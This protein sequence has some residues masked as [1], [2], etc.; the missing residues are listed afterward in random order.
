MCAVR[1]GSSAAFSAARPPLPMSRVVDRSWECGFGFG[2]V[3][4]KRTDLV[5][6]WEDSVFSFVAQETSFLDNLQEALLEQ[7]EP[8][9]LPVPADTKASSKLSQTFSLP[10]PKL[11]SLSQWKPQDSQAERQA[12]LSKWSQ[13]FRTVPHFFLEET[14]LEVVHE[15]SQVE[16]ATLCLV[17][18]TVCSASQ[19][20]R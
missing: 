7:P 19:P 4:R 8:V 9:P 12:A 16:L 13:L 1:F 3:K 15:N 18:S 20:G 17:V 10:Q 14:Q 2:E 5:L 6:P 11:R